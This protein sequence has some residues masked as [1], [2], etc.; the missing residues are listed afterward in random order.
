MLSSRPTPVAEL[1]SLLERGDEDGRAR[2]YP[3]ARGGRRGRRVDPPAVSRLLTTLMVGEDAPSYALV[4]AGRWVLL[5]EKERWPEGR[6]SPSTC[7]SSPNVI[8]SRGAARL[9]APD[10]PRRGLARAGARLGRHLVGRRPRGIRQ[11]HGR[12]LAGPPRRRPRVHRDHRQRGR[13]PASVRRPS[14]R[15]PATRL[16]RSR[17]SRSGSFTES[18]SSST[19][20]R[21]PNS[22]RFP[23]A[24][25]PTTRAT[26]STAYATL[27]LVEITGASRE[28]THLYESLGALFRL[29]DRGHHTAAARRDRRLRVRGRP[30]RGP[31]VT[32]CEPTSSRT[33]PS[34]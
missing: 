31:P 4:L 3:A 13:R 32:A 16:S 6:T 18:S 5:A 8:R 12:R 26:A 7:S 25:R 34:A 15:S 33:R 17:C 9:T 1:D 22:V 20:R 2:P 21:R 14:R 28:G 19:P 24:R 29:V 11:A 30:N 10:R 27:A 23:W